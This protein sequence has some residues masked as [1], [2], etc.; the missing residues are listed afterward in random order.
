MS[1]FHLLFQE[2][3]PIFFSIVWFQNSIFKNSYSFNHFIFFS[4]QISS[5]DF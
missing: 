4:P 3:L 1:F 5:Q 2:S